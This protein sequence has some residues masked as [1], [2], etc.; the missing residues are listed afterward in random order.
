MSTFTTLTLCLIFL[1]CVELT[2]QSWFIGVDVGYG[3]A[4]F[5]TNKKVMEDSDCNCPYY[6]SGS[7]PHKRVGM[8]AEYSVA[9]VGVG[10]LYLTGQLG[11]VNDIGWLNQEG[12]NLPSLDESGNVV[13]S[14]TSY[15]LNIELNQADLLIGVGL[16]SPNWALDASLI[17]GRVLRAETT[18]TLTLSAPI[19][20]VWDS[21]LFEQGE[22]E[23][24]ND[25]RTLI[26]ERH[27]TDDLAQWLY[28]VQIA[29][30][31]ITTVGNVQVQIVPYYR[32]YFNSV[33]TFATT[34]MQTIALDVR[35]G[36]ML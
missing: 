13:Y 18:N 1:G 27:G 3:R 14:S 33:H 20:A 11:Y 5:N 23:I 4:L 17:A 34:N 12:D 10:D 28:G 9:D 30:K 25:G 8:N 6:E 32:Y 2:A 7:G 21:T 29:A 26:F 22:V 31:Y 16:K 35:V 15:R 19:N 36:L 24:T